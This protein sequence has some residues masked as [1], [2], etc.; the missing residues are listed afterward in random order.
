MRKLISIYFQP[1]YSVRPTA[2]VP[3][4]SGMGLSLDIF[5]KGHPIIWLGS[6]DLDSIV[7]GPWR[8]I[9]SLRIVQ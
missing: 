8:G 1:W 2:L 5:A 3:S 4:T 7:A 6:H 9:N